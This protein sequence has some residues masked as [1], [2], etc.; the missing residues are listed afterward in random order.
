MDELQAVS[1]SVLSPS[2]L[3]LLKL[4]LCR[5][6]YPQLAVPDALN[7]SRKDSDQVPVPIHHQPLGFGGLCPRSGP[8]IWGLRGAH[9]ALAAD[10]PHQEQAGRRASPVLRL[11]HQ[12]GAAARQGGEGARR[13]QRWATP[14]SFFRT[15]F[16][17]ES[18]P[19]IRIRPPP[20]GGD[21]ERLRTPLRCP[22]C[23][24]RGRAEPP[25]PAPR[26]RLAA[27]DHQTLPGQLH[28]RAGAA[29]GLSVLPP[30]PPLPLCPLTAP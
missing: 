13:D 27:G 15:H 24:C 30:P 14:I 17:M 6:L 16:W 29:G 5:G 21:G 18:P 1:G 8:F 4:V 25:P 12:P 3:A 22:S 9:P 28:P 10:F 20:V 23:P 7:N 26:L 11:R 2:Q 19:G